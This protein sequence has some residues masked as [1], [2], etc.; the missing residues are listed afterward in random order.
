MPMVTRHARRSRRTT[1]HHG[2]RLAARHRADVHVHDPRVHHRGRHDLRPRL[3][4]EAGGC[5]EADL[6]RRGVARDGAEPRG[7]GDV[8]R[9]DQRQAHP[10]ERHG[11]G[12]RRRRG[13]GSVR[14]LRAVQRV[15]G[16]GHHVRV[17]QVQQVLRRAAQRQVVRPH[18]GRAQACEEV[19]GRVRGEVPG[20]GQ[21]HGPAEPGGVPRVGR[22]RG[23]GGRLLGEARHGLVREGAYRRRE[24]VRLSSSRN[25]RGIRFV[26]QTTTLSR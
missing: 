12:V 16:Q 20:R 13:G 2:H 15:R 3:P 6:P 24:G 8:R 11:Q 22:R 10:R 4:R 18:R 21:R 5:G 14:H 7:A 9:Q 1:G 26:F 19:R 17:R 23:A 25:V